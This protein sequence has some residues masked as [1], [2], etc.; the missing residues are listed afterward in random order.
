MGDREAVIKNVVIVDL[1]TNRDP[2]IQIGKPEEIQRPADAEE[3]KTMLVADMTT[4]C[5][6]IITLIHAGHQNGYVDSAESVRACIEYI[7]D[8]FVDETYET[9]VNV[10]KPE[11]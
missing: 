7:E 6:G 4:L 1:D 2:K 9:E 10:D 3:V 8:G 11:E 5:E